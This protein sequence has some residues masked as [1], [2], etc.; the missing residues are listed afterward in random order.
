[1]LYVLNKTQKCKINSR[2][3]QQ[4]AKE[5]A[6]NLRLQSELQRMEGRAA[7]KISRYQAAGTLLTNTGAI[8]S[9]K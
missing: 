8:L 4:K 7:E 6:T 9:M 3:Q 5:N 2:V 1:M